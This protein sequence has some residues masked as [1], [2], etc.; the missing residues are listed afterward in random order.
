MIVLRRPLFFA[1]SLA[2]LP[3]S[4]DA[5]PPWS[6]NFTDRLAVLALIEELNGAL[7]ASHS[8]TATLENWCASHQMANPSRLRAIVDRNSRKP[9]SDADRA[10][11]GAG[12][13][14]PVRYRRVQLACGTHVLSEAENWYLPARLP[15]GAD[16]LLDT[17][18]VPFGR[19]IST[20]HPSRQ[21]ISVERLWSPL[22]EG[23]E[24]H[25]RLPPS[26]VLST[27]SL[28]IP[29]ALFRHRALV[30]DASHRPIAVVVETYTRG[31]LDFSRQVS[32]PQTP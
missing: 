31:I 21:T 32:N 24:R 15:A 19:V 11:L 20:M 12:P 7:L 14:E 3:F 6:D 8:A 29:A 13:A 18:D 10:L 22:P 27:S 4:A 5:A 9:L 16:H 28:A 2:L 17:T 26:A 1:V 25:A 23:W 30:F